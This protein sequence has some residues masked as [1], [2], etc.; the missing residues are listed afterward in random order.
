MDGQ[1]M[2]VDHGGGEGCLFLG[3]SAD[4]KLWFLARD[5]VSAPGTFK[6]TYKEFP[7]IFP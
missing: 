7:E 5:I 4:A 1:G 2:L 6:L 3:R